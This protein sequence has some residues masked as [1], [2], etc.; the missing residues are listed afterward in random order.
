M[1]KA[2]IYGL[3]TLLLFTASGTALS[4]NAKEDF[5]KITNAYAGLKSISIDI[6]YVLFAD[7]KT[8]E[9]QEEK[10][11]TNIITKDLYYNKFGGVEIL[12][13]KSIAVVVDR[14]KKLLI[15]QPVKQ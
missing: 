4:Q 7:H 12:K 10:A 5:A 8:N 6:H 3:I 1:Y 2:R 14:E 15:L 9:K 13:D 11:G